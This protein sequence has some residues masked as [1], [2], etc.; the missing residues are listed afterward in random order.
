MVQPEIIFF[1]QLYDTGLKTKFFRENMKHYKFEILKP[2]T[3]LNKFTLSLQLSTL[4][5][6]FSSSLPLINKPLNRPP[7]S[8]LSSP[9][10]TLNYHAR[11]PHHRL[12]LRP[13]RETAIFQLQ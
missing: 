3:I 12:N 9:P 10:T 4:T 8:Q 7:S 13:T 11:T 6:S 1:E 5:I 2:E